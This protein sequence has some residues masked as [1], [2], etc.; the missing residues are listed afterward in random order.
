MSL[1]TVD[2]FGIVMALQSCQFSPVRYLFSVDQLNCCGSSLVF[3]PQAYLVI[4]NIDTCNEIKNGLLNYFQ[5][6]D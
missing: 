4:S 2:L 6:Q 5:N 1:A 3:L